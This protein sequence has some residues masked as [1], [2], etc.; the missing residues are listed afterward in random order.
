MAIV[1]KDIEA[2][3]NALN[4]RIDK[5]NRTDGATPEKSKKMYSQGIADII[6]T[7]IK[8]ADVILAPGTIIV[9]DPVSGPIVNTVQVKGKLIWVET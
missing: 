6:E 1:N 7:A 8:S 2:G 9:I 4:E 5:Y 3:V